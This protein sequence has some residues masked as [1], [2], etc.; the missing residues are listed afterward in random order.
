MGGCI[1]P[2]QGQSS[3]E[4]LHLSSCTCNY[5]DLADTPALWWDWATTFGALFQESSA[6][7][8]R[9]VFIWL[10]Q[11]VVQGQRLLRQCISSF[12]FAT[13]VGSVSNYSVKQPS[14]SKVPFFTQML[15]LGPEWFYLLVQRQTNQYSMYW[16]WL[17][18]RLS[19]ET[20]HGTSFNSHSLLWGRWSTSI[21]LWG[22]RSLKRLE[23]VPSHVNSEG[24]SL[25]SPFLP[26]KH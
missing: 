3:V 26:F 5:Q 2:C 6:V 11:V 23:N 19:A 24:W 15:H 8:E 9:G 14:K 20:P 17:C 7:S 16:H 18:P 13:F 25:L 4:Q 1:Y 12:S 22:R 10:L 21:I